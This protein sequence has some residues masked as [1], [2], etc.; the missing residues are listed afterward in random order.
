MNQ[1]R[2]LIGKS[3]LLI[4]Y[5]L[6]DLDSG[7]TTISTGLSVHKAQVTEGCL[8]LQSTTKEPTYPLKSNHKKRLISWLSNEG[9]LVSS[10]HQ[11]VLR[12]ES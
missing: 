3:I 1:L 11:L 7:S 2:L 10:L 6:T 12:T 5:I 9:R 4:D 8:S